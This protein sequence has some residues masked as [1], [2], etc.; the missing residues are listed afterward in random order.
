MI[1]S[2][3]FS[4]ISPGQI[5]SQTVEP[6][7]IYLFHSINQ[8]NTSPFHSS[9]PTDF[10][11][12]IDDTCSWLT[13]TPAI[14]FLVGLCFL[15]PSPRYLSITGKPHTAKKLLLVHRF[16]M[17]TIQA[18]VDTWLA[19]KDVFSISRLVGDDMKY[20]RLFSPFLG[21]TLLEL[22]MGPVV[23]LFYLQEI[24][25]YICKWANPERDLIESVGWRG[26]NYH[27]LHP[28]CLC[29]NFINR[30]FTPTCHHS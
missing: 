21:L 8:F 6:S 27:L 23:I 25:F 5:K 22:C 17:A 24:C 4:I 2:L 28:I 18:D 16:T 19:S 14:I 7:C 20:I 30:F 10:V 15:P 12:Y 26:N 3:P 13:I 29:D 1:A 11:G 9:T